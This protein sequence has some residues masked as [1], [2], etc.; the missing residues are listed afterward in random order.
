MDRKKDDSGQ[1]L[2]ILKARQQRDQTP[3]VKIAL[4]Q[5][6]DDQ[7]IAHAKFHAEE[8]PVADDTFRNLKN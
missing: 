3:V 1:P 8:L 4:E 5:S 2:L 7:G 6:H